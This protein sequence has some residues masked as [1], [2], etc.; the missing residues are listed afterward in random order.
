[1]YGLCTELYIKSTKDSSTTYI[2]YITRF[3]QIVKK[4]FERCKTTPNSFIGCTNRH[5]FYN[6]IDFHLRLDHGLNY[7]KNLHSSLSN[8]FYKLL[9]YYLLSNI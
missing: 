3:T 7:L 9:E 6:N 4:S 5:F 1:M 2:P 8:M